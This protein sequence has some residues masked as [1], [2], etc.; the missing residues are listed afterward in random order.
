MATKLPGSKKAL[1]G[2]ENLPG[3][4][5][6]RSGDRLLDIIA[7]SGKDKD[8]RP[9][10]APSEEQKRLLKSMQKIVAECADGL[11]LSAEIIAPRKELSAAI[12]AGRTD[13]RVFSGWR[14]ELVGEKLLALL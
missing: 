10:S 3:K 6:Q 9:P 4:V 2:I 7:K 13:S 14:R 1:L 5:V 12:M 11:A 8:Y